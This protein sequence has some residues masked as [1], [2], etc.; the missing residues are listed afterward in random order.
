MPRAERLSLPT[1][2]S[3]LKYETVD[4]VGL[5]LETSSERTGADDFDVIAKLILA[6]THGNIGSHGGGVRARK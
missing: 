3:M 6:P 2:K 1:A 4:V 5:V